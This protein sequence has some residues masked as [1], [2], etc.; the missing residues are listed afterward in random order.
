M[1]VNTLSNKSIVLDCNDSGFVILAKQSGQPRSRIWDFLYWGGGGRGECH[2][3][4]IKIPINNNFMC[5]K[6]TG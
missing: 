4:L 3:R 6:N 1:Y 5:Y 2:K